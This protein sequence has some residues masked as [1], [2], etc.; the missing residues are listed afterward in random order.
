MKWTSVS[1]PRA[2]HRAQVPQFLIRDD[3]LFATNMLK[4]LKKNIFTILIQHRLTWIHKTILQSLTHPSV[5]VSLERY[6]YSIQNL[7]RV[8]TQFLQRIEIFQYKA[9][10]LV[11]IAYCLLPMPK[12]VV[13]DSKIKVKLKSRATSVENNVESETVVY[14]VFHWQQYIKDI[15]KTTVPCNTFD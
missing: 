10:P 15:R 8:I 5:N 6:S 11:T 2:M 4:N 12:F 9:K 14:T 3:N 7:L 1:H 13:I